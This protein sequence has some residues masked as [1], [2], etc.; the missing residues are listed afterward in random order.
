MQQKTQVIYSYT[1]AFESE[2]LQEHYH[3]NQVHVE[4]FITGFIKQLDHYFNG[5]V[6]YLKTEN[7][8]EFYCPTQEQQQDVRV[9]CNQ[10][11]TG[12]TTMLLN[13]WFIEKVLSDV[14]V[15]DQILAEE[16]VKVLHNIDRVK[17]IG[18]SRD[19]QQPKAA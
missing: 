15:Y 9:I 16:A 1:V 14:A 8:M 5:K 17:E 3:I 11:F 6:R 10:L 7:S 12:L 2:Q 19:E 18:A 13:P 4:H